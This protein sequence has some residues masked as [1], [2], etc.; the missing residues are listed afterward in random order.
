MKKQ[1]CNWFP[2]RREGKSVHSQRIFT[3]P[4]SAIETSEQR[5]KSV[6]S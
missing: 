4:N 5:V 2:D 6:Q 1:T 3:C